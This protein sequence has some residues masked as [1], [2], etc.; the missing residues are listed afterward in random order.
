MNLP[1]PS[2]TRLSALKLP[3]LRR[4]RWT[5]VAGQTLTML[6]VAHGLGVPLPFRQAFWVIGFTAVTNLALHGLPAGRGESPRFLA[7]VLGMDVVLLTLLLGFTGGPHN[8]FATLYLVM[9][10]LAAVASTPALTLGIAGLS[11]LGYGWLFLVP[12][13]APRPGDPVC[14]VGPN[15][16]LSIHLRGMM[17]AFGMTSVLVAYFVARLQQALRRHEDD[18]AAARQQAAEH[19]RFAAMATLAAGAAHELG[20]PLGSIV[21]AAGE[22]ARE[23]KT[24][25][26]RPGL[27]EDAELIRQEAFRCRAILDRLQ[28]QAEDRPAEVDPAGLFGV[29]R[30]RFPTVRFESGGR[31]SSAR[32]VAP[33]EALT[34]AMSNL[35]GNALDASPPDKPVR[36]GWQETG[37]GIDFT[38][39][40]AGQGLDPVAMAH[41][42][43]PFFT[44]KPAGQG[45]GLGL[46]LVRLLARRLAGEFRFETPSQGGTRAVL[47]LPVIVEKPLA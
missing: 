37:R 40:D 10:A 29:L 33:P 31:K 15:L 36:V 23:A 43:E 45:M 7:A 12:A 9:V 42:G 8:P 39:T 32:V 18:L 19:E 11:C 26:D 1:H 28:H 17:V 34:Q 44:T 3:W 14:G 21:V 4:L 13:V 35:I 47:S 46:F 20:T 5:A 30:D 25:A 22:L 24:V 2:V 41:A 27:L 38:V 16:P 6:F